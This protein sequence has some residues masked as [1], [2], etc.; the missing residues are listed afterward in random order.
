MSQSGEAAALAVPR[1]PPGPGS[2][3]VDGAVPA[4]PARNPVWWMFGL[5]TALLLGRNWAL[6]RTPMVEEGDAAAN[7]ILVDN[8]KQFSQL[9]GNYSRVGF[10]HPGPAFLYVH[11]LGEWLF[12]DVLGVVPSEWNGQAVAVLILN[13][14]LIAIAVGIVSRWLRGPESPRWVDVAVAGTA[15]IFLGSW[16]DL[17]T[18]TWPP[19]EYF[20]PY[21]L[22]LAAA[23]SVAAGGVR[24]LWALCLAT[25]LLVH[26]HAEFLLLANG[27]AGVAV[28]ALLFPRRRRL[29]GFLREH[30]GSLLRAVPVVLLALLPI[31]LDLVLHWPGEFGRYFG[32][33]DS[34]APNDLG[35]AIWYVVQAWDKDQLLAAP[36]LAGC[37]AA[38]ALATRR[39]GLPYVRWSL[40]F[41]VLALASVLGYAVVGIDS[42]DQ[43]YILF[44]TRALP[45]FALMVS[46]G[47]TVRY[48]QVPAQWRLLLTGA[49]ATTALLLGLASP[50]MV[51]RQVTVDDAPQAL[52]RVRGTDDQPIV[53]H[54]ATAASWA[55]ALP[56]ALEGHR[57]GVRMCFVDESVLMMATPAFMCTPAETATG[58]SVTV[59]R[60]GTVMSGQ[61]WV[62][63]LGLSRI[64]RPPAR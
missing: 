25:G 59:A 1:P 56:L 11:A 26:G 54:L 33:G 41:V 52:A 27:L 29:G 51:N 39:S 2:T 12:H 50:A 6:F 38:L 61:Q 16:V 24:D 45:M 28:V 19:F 63:D 62:S 22:L 40:V 5:L 36:V 37:L 23:T 34:Q 20:A 21:L 32:Y 15:L 60:W 43:P 4:R 44:F 9:V 46:V 30:R 14:A 64:W 35:P 17:A 10:H 7:S 55:E 48:G 42:L 13:A 47:V 57:H 18:S 49:L 58:R 3:P 53:L 31:G 8:A